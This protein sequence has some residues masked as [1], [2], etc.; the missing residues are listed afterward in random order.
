MS[1]MLVLW[2]S[3]ERSS[4][5]PPVRECANLAVLTLSTMHFLSK[6]S[7]PPTRINAQMYLYNE[8]V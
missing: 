4:L 5:D 6:V 1:R 8:M 7:V 3:E 2:L